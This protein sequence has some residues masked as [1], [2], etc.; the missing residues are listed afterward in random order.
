VA[1]VGA[2]LIRKHS[3]N[4]LIPLNSESYPEIV[5]SETLPWRQFCAL[6]L[7]VAQRGLILGRKLNVA[8]G[9]AIRAFRHSRIGDT[10]APTD[11]PSAVTK[12][13]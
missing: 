5:A 13:D 9:F 7:E 4:G 12:V 3:W 6:A 2:K 1:I 8:W 11:A 10:E